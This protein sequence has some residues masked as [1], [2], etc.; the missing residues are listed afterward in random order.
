MTLRYRMYEG[1]GRRE[2]LRSYCTSTGMAVTV[3]T[4]WPIIFTT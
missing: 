4:A 1:G 2:V 3:F